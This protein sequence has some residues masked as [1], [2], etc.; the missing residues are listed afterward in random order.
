MSPAGVSGDRKLVV[1]SRITEVES[2][3][4]GFSLSPKYMLY[5]TNNKE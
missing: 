3:F 4:F 1:L 2:N 5:A